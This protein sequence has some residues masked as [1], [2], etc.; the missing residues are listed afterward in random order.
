MDKPTEIAQQQFKMAQMLARNGVL[1]TKDPRETGA[2]FGALL[3]IAEGL[4][5]LSVGLRATYL[6][7][8]EVNRKLDG[9]R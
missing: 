2:M 5:H 7:L 9:R 4:D 8:D 6:L 3:H 1:D